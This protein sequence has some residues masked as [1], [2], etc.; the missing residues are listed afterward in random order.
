MYLFSMYLLDEFSLFLCGLNLLLIIISNTSLI[1]PGPE[2]SNSRPLKVLYNNMH[3]FI[4]FSHLASESPPLNRTKLSDLHGHIYAHKPDVI[5]LNETWLKKSILD[6]ETLPDCYKVYRVDRTKAS[7]PW[8]PDAPKKFRKNGGGVLIAHR[9]DVDI[10]SAK[11]SIIKVQAEILSIRL[12]L[13]GNR[14]ICIST[15]YRTGTLAIENFEE[16]KRYFE[17]LAL[18][19]KIDKHI[20]IGDLNLSSVTWPGGTTTNQLHRSFVEFFQEDLGHTQVITEPTHIGGNVL[21]LLFTNVPNLVEDVNVLEHNEVCLSDHYGIEFTIRLNVARKQTTRPKVF[22]YRKADW[23]GLNYDLGQINWDIVVGARDIYTAWPL[24]K[25]ILDK[26]C[27]KHI[28]KKAPRS[29]FQPPWFDSDCEAIY[30]RKEKWRKK[31]KSES[32]TLFDRNKCKR[33]RKELKRTMHE[34]MALN[35]VDDSDPALIPKKFWSHVTSR[36]KSTRIPESVYYGSR[37]RNNSKDQADLFN[38]YFY[39]QFS[40]PSEYNIDID[41]SNSNNSS[42]DLKFHVFD[43]YMILKDLNPSKAAGPDGINGMVLKKCASRLAKPLSLMYNISYVTGCIPDEWKLASIVPVHKKGDKASVENYRPISLTSLVMKVFERC[44]KTELLAICEESIDPRQ[45]GFVNHKSCTTQ[46]IPFIDSLT[47]SLNNRSRTD[48]IYFDFAKAFDTVSH[49]LILHKLKTQYNVDGLMLN[50]I[51]GYLQGRKQQVVVGGSVSSSKDVNSGVPQG[52]IL[53]PLL[54][55]LFIN[56]MFSRV[57]EGTNIALYADDT[58]IWREIRSWNDHESLD[59]DIMNLL[60]WS[61]E[62]KMV[63]HPSKCKMLSVTLQNNVLDELPFNIY[64]YRLGDEWI[65]QVWSHRDL[66]LRVNYRLNWAPHIYELVSRARSRLGLL[67]R[68]VGHLANNRQK[69]SFYLAICR[70]MFEHCSIVWCTLY[71]THI[72][73]FDAFQRKGIKFIDGNP[74]CSY[75][76]EEYLAKQRQYNILPMTK[77]FKFNDLKDLYKIVIGQSPITLPEYVSFV[78]HDEVRLTRSTAAIADGSDTTTLQCSVVHETDIFRNSFFP[79]ATRLWN[80]LPVDI[81]QSSCITIFKKKLIAFLW[82][83]SNDWPD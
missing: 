32:A 44:I 71:A 37:F 60:N 64:N 65:D 19:K 69:R 83:A 74:Y 38:E 21:D 52:S 58:K 7:H 46:M 16:V 61:I 72:A 5:I 36:S 11:I 26:L 35:F 48:V 4:D 75:S 1:N 67:I 47:L 77:W 39:K 12:S 76:E 28:P 78:E 25:T 55:V 66:G 43:I 23:A 31:A 80:V 3:G 79:R 59:Q 42:I 13:S 53:G 82:A 2:N 50:F 45:H 73:Q 68:T 81:R 30:K 33:L 49:D 29:Q 56:D 15:L 63:F 14:K 20:L 6:V 70:S 62:N 18:K 34:K 22:N 8:D 40:Q 57:S 24:F 27:N 10:I 9:T 51:K 54:F 17:K 41:M